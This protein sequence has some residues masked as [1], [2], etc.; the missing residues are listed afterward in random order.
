M[1]K[2]WQE[3]SKYSAGKFVVFRH[4]SP[5]YHLQVMIPKYDP[6][7]T[8]KLCE[9]FQSSSL[10]SNDISTRVVC[11]MIKPPISTPL[12]SSPILYI[13]PYLV[14]PLK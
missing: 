5:F 1:H 2:M 14:S 4:F 12:V 7:V 3:A 6:T 11:L 13:L 8:L 9:V 10:S